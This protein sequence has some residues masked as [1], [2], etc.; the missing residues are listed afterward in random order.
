MCAHLMLIH[1]PL[2]TEISPPSL[3]NATSQGAG[4]Q[5]QTKPKPLIPRVPFSKLD[6]LLSTKKRDWLCKT[7]KSHQHRDERLALLNNKIT[8]Q[9]QSYKTIYTGSIS[10]FVGFTGL[11]LAHTV[12]NML[13]VTLLYNKRGLYT[14][15]DQPPHKELGPLLVFPR[16]ITKSRWDPYGVFSSAS[17]FPRKGS[18]RVCFLLVSWI[19][20]GIFKVA[21]RCP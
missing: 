3:N 21:P 6:L 11:M 7:T 8:P 16:N 10:V 15:K 17:S 12:P 13:M 20:L 4:R 1:L 18:K 19:P 2:S 5:N 9:L 14:T